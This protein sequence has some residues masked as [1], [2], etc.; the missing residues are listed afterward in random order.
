MI[1]VI[2]NDTLREQ[3]IQAAANAYNA[4]NPSQWISAEQYMQM[5]VEGAALSYASQYRVGVISSGAFVLRF[6]P[7][8]YAGIETASATDPI[9]AGFL[10]RVQESNEVVLY[11]DEVVQG[12]A[13]LVA[14][15]LL[16]QQRSEE[17]LAYDVPVNPAEPVPE[18]EPEPE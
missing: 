18:P 13:Y 9:V 3:G 11:A 4:A 2:I 15:S 1:T 14:Q 7:S 8:E 17:I 5:V 12:L 16:T 10:A 6:T